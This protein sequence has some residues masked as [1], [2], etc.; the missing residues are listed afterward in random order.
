MIFMYDIRLLDLT[1]ASWSFAIFQKVLLHEN[2]FKLNMR[3]SDTRN[4]TGISPGKNCLVVSCGHMTKSHL[5]LVDY[6]LISI[7]RKILKIILHYL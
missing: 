3:L 1:L 5:S 7:K 2:L 6:H 4:S